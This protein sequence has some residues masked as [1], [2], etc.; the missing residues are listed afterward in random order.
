MA[1]DCC[2]HRC[3]G[4]VRDPRSQKLREFEPDPQIGAGVMQGRKEKE[5]EC[6]FLCVHHMS[7]A[8]RPLSTAPY[9]DSALLDESCADVVPR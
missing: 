9:D 5:T 3:G 7:T 2:A 6:T 4:G 8:Q 1:C